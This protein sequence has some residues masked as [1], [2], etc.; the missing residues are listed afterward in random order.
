MTSWIDPK[1]KWTG[2]MEP[3]WEP[4]RIIYGKMTPESV[5]AYAKKEPSTTNRSFLSNKLFLKEAVHLLYTVRACA[6]KQKK[7]S[8]ASKYKFLSDREY[9]EQSWNLQFDKDNNTEWSKSYWE[10]SHITR[11]I[12]MFQDSK[13]TSAWP[14]YKFISHCTFDIKFDRKRARCKLLEWLLWL[15]LDTER[16]FYASVWC[17]LILWN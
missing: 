3:T 13:G 5:R 1:I 8:L 2:Y 9:Q 4:S 14:D 15:P 16:W 10:R 6:T 17:H 11:P 12:Q 7:K